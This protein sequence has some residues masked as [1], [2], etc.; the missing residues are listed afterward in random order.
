M[1]PTKP[2]KGGARRL[3][4]PLAL[5]QLTQAP[6]Q[7]DKLHSSTLVALLRKEHVTVAGQTVTITDAGRQALT[8]FLA[9]KPQHVQLI[10]PTPVISKLDRYREQQATWEQGRRQP[11]LQ[12]SEELVDGL[13]RLFDMVSRHPDGTPFGFADHYQRKLTRHLSEPTLDFPT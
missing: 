8:E 2:M 1:I 6:L 9:T 13:A 11:R 4:G 5:H 10:Q 7:L 12:P 3:T